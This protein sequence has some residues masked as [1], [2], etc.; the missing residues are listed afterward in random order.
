MTEN[1]YKESMERIIELNEE[2]KRESLVVSREWPPSDSSFIEDDVHQGLRYI[3]LQGPFAVCG[4]V[5]VPPGH[6]DAA[7]E[8][9]DIGV[10][11]HGG[12]TFRCLDNEGFH[13]YGWD[14]G[15]YGEACE[16]PVFETKLLAAQF[17]QRS[18]Q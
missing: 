10:D 3:V 11:V 18:L 14:N 13:W 1:E 15:H 9:D 2:H 5:R 6:P 8:Y 4:Y 12:L 17:A 16:D 7:K